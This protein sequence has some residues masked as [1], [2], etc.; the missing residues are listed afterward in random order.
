MLNMSASGILI[1]ASEQLLPGSRL[2]L[3]VDWPG[4]F[5]GKVQVRLLILG[6]VVRCEDANIALRI[7]RHEFQSLESSTKKTRAATAAA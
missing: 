4:F 1:G 2:D 3:L 6:E 5:H 7:L